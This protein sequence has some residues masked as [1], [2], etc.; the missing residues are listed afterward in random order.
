MA[1]FSLITL[2]LGATLPV[3][4]IMLLLLMLSVWSWMHIINKFVALRVARNHIE[5]FERIFWSGSDLNVLNQNL[6]QSSNAVAT[7]KV[8]VAGFSEFLRLHKQRVDRSEMIDS[9]R[10]AMKAVAQ[11]E[12]DELE[13]YI[14]FLATVSSSSPYIGLFGTV[15]GIMH[16]FLALS[17]ADSV[18]LNAVA[19]GIAEALIATAVG[20][21][22]AIPAMIAYNRFSHEVDVIAVQIESFMEEFLNLLQRQLSN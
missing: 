13:R 17:Q 2:V 4:L 7:E 21:F 5:E 18:S 12:L 19:P 9:A 14:P 16:S 10:R 3:Q 1:E 8:F 15:W 22:A 20:L 11:R 6:R